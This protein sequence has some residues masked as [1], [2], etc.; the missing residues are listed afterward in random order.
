MNTC[1]SMFR[2]IV[3]SILVS[4]MMASAPACADA[5]SAPFYLA[6]RGPLMVNSGLPGPESAQLL[7]PGEFGVG[8]FLDVTS[9]ATFTPGIQENVTLDGQTSYADLRIRYGVLKNWELGIDLV[10]LGHSGGNLD[11][12]IE[13]WHNIFSLT[14]GDRD[15]QPNGRLLYNYQK[16]GQVLLDHQND[17]SGIGDVRLSAAYQIRKAEDSQLTVRGGVE[18][19]TGDADDLLGSESTDLYLEL[20]NSRILNLEKYALRLNSGLGILIHGDSEI[21]PKQQNDQIGYGFVG[22]DWGVSDTIHLKLQLNA[23]TSPYT[24]KA[25]ELDSASVI[26]IMGGTA[27]LAPN[28]LLDVSVGEDLLGESPDTTFQ[29]GI[30]YQLSAD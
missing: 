30:R 6:N 16:D 17:T 1:N 10:W 2:G 29:L 18:L 4:I 8:M 19:G 9:S 28:W 11:G 21:L 20:V 15:K 7:P 5:I 22:L 14:N 25:R 23:H 12:F 27:R 3:L 13:D 26:L 24:G